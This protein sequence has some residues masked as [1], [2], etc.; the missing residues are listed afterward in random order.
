M[1]NRRDSLPRRFPQLFHEC[2]FCHSV[3][4]RPGI[5]DT[6]H[7]DYGMRDSFKEE[8]ELILNQSGLCEDCIERF[9][10]KT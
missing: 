2:A 5:L 1:G 3:G 7:G 4:L 10:T 6:K 9:N 8:K